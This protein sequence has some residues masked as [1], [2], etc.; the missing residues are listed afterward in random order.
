[1]TTA[2][3]NRRTANRIHLDLELE[4]VSRMIAKAQHSASDSAVSYTRNPIKIATKTRWQRKPK[5]GGVKTENRCCRGVRVQARHAISPHVRP[6]S[7]HHSFH[8]TPCS[9]PGA[10]VKPRHDIRLMERQ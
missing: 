4:T 8:F 1:M 7:H 9:S 3:G 6:K 5:K 10:R 2:L